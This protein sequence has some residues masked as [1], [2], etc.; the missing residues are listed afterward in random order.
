MITLGCP[1]SQRAFK[2]VGVWRKR[3]VKVPATACNGMA[4]GSA[5]SESIAGGAV[6]VVVVA[7]VCAAGRSW[8]GMEPT[9]EEPA[10]A[11]TT[12]TN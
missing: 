1:G 3:H 5:G 7:G 2:D 9:R 11:E 10:E 12:G 4:D 6:V 8:A